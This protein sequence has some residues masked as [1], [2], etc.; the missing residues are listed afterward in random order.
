MQGKLELDTI[1]CNGAISAS[2]RAKQWRRALGVLAKMDQHGV[3]T[4][5]TSYNAAVATFRRLAYER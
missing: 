2:G 1:A 3:E 4:Q 5:E